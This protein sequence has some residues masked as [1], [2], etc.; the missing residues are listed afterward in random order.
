MPRDLDCTRLVA[1]SLLP[2]S[3]KSQLNRNLLSGC[4]EKR[5]I[6]TM[7]RESETQFFFIVIEKGVV[8]RAVDLFSYNGPVLVDFP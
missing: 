1:S 8:Q 4:W 7:R 6:K 2:R 5:S 3:K